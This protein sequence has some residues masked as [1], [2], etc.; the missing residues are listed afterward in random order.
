MLKYIIK[1]SEKSGIVEYNWLYSNYG[2]ICRLPK[3][4]MAACVR[5]LR[6]EGYLLPPKPGQVDSFVCP[7]HDAY[8]K[9]AITW[10]KVKKI[11]FMSVF[12]PIVVAASTSLITMWITGFF[13]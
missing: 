3:H 9:N 2:E 4:R 8:R 6:E 10:D 1:S 11:L 12:T 7:N 13:R 5:Y